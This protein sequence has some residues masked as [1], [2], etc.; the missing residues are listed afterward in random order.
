VTDTNKK[1]GDDLLKKNKFIEGTIFAYIIILLTKVI[2]ALY[3]IP[4]RRIIGEAGGALYSYAYEVYT[5][6]LDISTSGIPTAIS[7][8]IAEY[9][10]LKMFNER[11]F[12]YSV[13]HKLIS[14]ISV[15]AFLAMF[16]LAKPIA[17]YY[18]S[19]IHAFEKIPEIT[20]V[21]RVISFCILVI[22]F[23]SIS[24]GYLQG[25]KYVSSSSS[26]Q[27]VEQLVRVFVAL[28]GSYIA[29]N[30]LHLDLPIG[31]SVA[32]S[33]TVLGGLCAYLMLRYKIKKNKAQLLEGVTNPNDST[34]TSKEVIKKIVKRAV[35]VIIV[36]LTQ[37]IYNIIDHKLLMKGLFMIGFPSEQAEIIGSVVVSW[38]PKVCMIINSIAVGMCISIIPFIVSSFVN[39]DKKELNQKFNQAINTILYIS[40]PLALFINAFGASVYSI[41]YKDVEYG[42]V[43][44]GVNAILSIVFSVQMIMD[45]M[46]QSMKNYKLVYINTAIGLITNII[47]DIPIIVFLN[48]MGFHP[49]IGTIIASMI[50]QTVSILIIFIGSKKKYGFEFKSILKVLFQILLSSSIM[51]FVI[52]ML[53]N[54]KPEFNG[55]LDKFISL[56]IFGF[57]S[58]GIYVLIT[59]ALGTMKAVLG[60]D[61][62]SNITNK[63]K[64][65]S[66]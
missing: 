41:F 3:V 10:A 30:V 53:K 64:K 63:F 26:S 33:G 37:N 21:I 44:L 2:G 14:I 25:N 31:V 60:E 29:L 23:L 28:V 42:G 22:P 6:F 20:L 45:M 13:A 55:T 9:N 48:D 12:A 7:M 36:A 34:V 38:T 57:I 39:N 19:D 58:I 15:I 56:F 52:F 27:L 35:P 59:Y 8:I 66:T 49:Y 16:I 50:G 32:L 62:I 47:L 46:L 4:F 18:V 1:F 65:K 11:E 54:L 24:R 51:L 40:I 17:Y 5:L 43:V 61:F